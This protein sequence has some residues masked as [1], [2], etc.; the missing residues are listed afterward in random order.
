MRR[1]GWAI[2]VGLLLLCSMAVFASTEETALPDWL[3]GE[4]SSSKE[5]SSTENSSKKDVSEAEKADDQD[6]SAPETNA[7]EIEKATASSAEWTCPQCETTVSGNFCNNC[8]TQKPTAEWT[9]PNCGEIVEGNFCNICGTARNGGESD[10]P[11]ETETHSTDAAVSE[12]DT[13]NSDIA[14]ESDTERDTVQESETA[15]IWEN[16]VLKEEHGALGELNADGKTPEANEIVFGVSDWRRADITAVYVLDNFVGMPENAIDI[17]AVQDGSVMGWLDAN[18]ALYIAGEGGVKAHKNAAALFAWFENAK[19]IRLNGNLHTDHCTTFKHM[20]YHLPNLEVLDI[21]G[22]KTTNAE[23][24][25]KMFCGCRKVPNLDVSQFETT[26]VKSFFAMFCK[27]EMLDTLDITSF[28]TRSATTTRLMFSGCSNLRGI[29]W[30]NSLFNTHLVDTMTEMFEDC[31]SLTSLDLSGFDFSSVGRMNHMFENCVSL[32][33]INLG[34]ISLPSSISHDGVFAGSS[35]EPYYGT[36]AELW[37]DGSGQTDNQV[38]ET[39]ADNAAVTLYDAILDEYRDA[40]LTYD[41]VQDI[42]YVRSLYPHVN[43]TLV[44]HQYA[45]PEYNRLYYA[46]Y[47]IDGNGSGEL[48]IGLG[49]PDGSYVSCFDIFASDGTGI[50]KFFDNESLGERSSLTVYTDGTI[51]FQGSNGAADGVVECWVI[52]S[53]GATPVSVLAY[54]YH[55]DE[56]GQISYSDVTGNMLPVDYENS[57]SEKT[58]VSVTGWTML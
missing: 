55:Y 5:D 51:H 35:L 30:D 44:F 3:T 23:D 9:C 8:G 36:N 6:I 17:S 24:F 57:L 48:L 43:T 4:E 53:D 50:T 7:A 38:V 15:A 40:V 26:K 39:I 52:G 19:E 46:Y 33:S 47:D 28:D 12:V 22:M 18:N 11:A 1:T 21:Q 27:C 34:N 42:D 45:W 58:P 37:F 54:S 49:T 41:S 13:D 14:V 29:I 20:F 16:N 25:T 2:F 56:T 10:A 31:P 32:Q